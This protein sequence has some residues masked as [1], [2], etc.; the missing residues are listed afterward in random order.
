M[1]EVIWHE[2]NNSRGLNIISQGVSPSPMFIKI[3][4]LILRGR[5]V[6]ILLVCPS[7]AKGNKKNLKYFEHEGVPAGLL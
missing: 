7:V 5:T 1:K 2:V 3:H 6:K 4:I